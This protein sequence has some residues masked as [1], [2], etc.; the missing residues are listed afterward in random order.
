MFKQD[1]NQYT[2]AKMVTDFG[3]E[4][5]EEGTALSDDD[6]EP[7]V[8]TAADGSRPEPQ[9]VMQ[10]QGRISTEVVQELKPLLERMLQRFVYP[11]L[12]LILPCYQ[13]LRN[14][15]GDLALHRLSVE[16]RQPAQLASRGS[17]E[18]PAAYHGLILRCPSLLQPCKIIEKQEC[19]LAYGRYKKLTLAKHI[20][21][22]RPEC[23]LASRRGAEIALQIASATR[24]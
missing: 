16:A 22:C 14:S 19:S 10:A 15:L 13:R 6:D 2:W 12:H 5:I 7:V 23:K 9:P 3:D 24:E 20:L 1:A 11:S 8:T 18:L 4:P 21:K 17:C